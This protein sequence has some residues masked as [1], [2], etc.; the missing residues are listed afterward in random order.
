MAIDT[1]TIQYPLWNA[2]LSAWDG[3]DVY[4]P[5]VFVVVVAEVLGDDVELDEP[6]VDP[7][8]LLPPLSLLEVF[9]VVL[10][11]LPL[12]VVEVV[13]APVVEVVE[14]PVVLDDVDEVVL[15]AV[16]VT[17]GVNVLALKQA[18]CHSPW[19]LTASLA[20]RVL[21]YFHSNST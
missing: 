14:A 11:P 19:I 21:G 18:P 17:L 7:S 5:V 15:V 4:F 13:E 20:L 2:I 10:V 6:W 12:P 3:I 16:E 8:L 1:A 9:E